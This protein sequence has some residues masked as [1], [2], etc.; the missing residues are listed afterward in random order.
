MAKLTLTIHDVITDEDVK[1]KDVSIS[2]GD[3]I[4]EGEFKRTVDF[5]QRP[6]SDFGKWEMAEQAASLTFKLSIS[7]FNVHQMMYSPDKIEAE[8]LIQAE[9]SD[10]HERKA[11]FSK[12]D[13]VGIFAKKRVS[14]TYCNT[15]KST[16]VYTV[17]SDY[18]V[19]EVVPR[20]S[21]DLMYVTLNIYSPDKLL[22]VKKYFRS[23]TAKKLYKNVLTEQ[24]PNYKLPYDS[25]KKVE[26]DASQMKHLINDTQEHIIPYLVQYNESFY[27][28]LARTTNRWGE[29]MYYHDGKLHIGFDADESKAEEISNYYSVTYRDSQSSQ[30]TQENAGSYVPEDPYDYNTLNT[31]T[32]ESSAGRTMATIMNALDMDALGDVYWMQKVRQIFACRESVISLLFNTLVDDLLMWY[33]MDQRMEDKNDKL[34]Q[35]YFTDKTKQYVSMEPE[36]YGKAGSTTTY[37]Q[38]SEAEPILTPEKYAEI[39]VGEVSAGDNT[40]EIDYDTYAPFLHIG[41]LIKVDDAPYIVTEITATQADSFVIVDNSYI[42]KRVDPRKMLFRVKA[43]AKVNLQED[44]TAIMDDFYPPVIP[45][46][47]IRQ[48]GPQIAVVVDADDPNQANRV[49]VK[50]PWQLTEEIAKLPEQESSIPLRPVYDDL[51]A[52]SLKDLDLTDATPWLLYAS[53]SGPHF[54]GVHARHYLAEKVIVNYAN[55]NIERPY[56][57]GAVSRDIPPFLTLNE[58]SAI[59]MSP[60]G[61]FI[62]LH[63]G[64]GEGATAFISKLSPGLNMVKNFFSFDDWFGDNEKS[65]YFEGG[66]EMSD[67]YGI[68]SIKCSTDSRCVMVNSPWGNVMVNAFTGIMLNAPNGD[69]RISGKNVSIEAGNNLTLTSGTNI[70]NKFASISRDKDGNFSMATFGMDVANIVGKKIISLVSSVFDLSILR[71]IVEIFW[72]PQE[73]CLTLQSNRYM[74]LSAGGARAGY[75]DAA[76]KHPEKKAKK[77]IEASTD[78]LHKD[79]AGIEQV[80]S[81]KIP[82]L[83]DHMISSYRIQ[84]NLCRTKK[85]KFDTSIR[86]LLE[87]SDANEAQNICKTY[88]QLKELFWNPATKE[89]T[90]ANL[91]FKKC[92]IADANN[93]V[94]D[95]S[96]HR[97]NVR[98]IEDVAQRR[99]EII[100]KRKTLREKVL[101]EA[102]NLL[103]AITDLRT[104][105]VTDEDFTQFHIER[106]DASKDQFTDFK[107][108]FEYDKLKDTSFYK[109]FYHKEEAV[110]DLRRDLEF[111]ANRV[112][113]ESKYHKVALMRKVAMQLAEQWGM[114]QQEIRKKINDQNVVVDMEAIEKAKV[115]DKPQTEADL[116]NNAKW[117]LYTASLTY[118]KDAA[119]APSE[120]AVAGLMA[121]D[122]AIGFATTIKDYYSWGKPN[123]GEILF[124]TGN[125]LSL[126]KDGSISKLN[127]K[128]NSA[129]LSADAISNDEKKSEFLSDIS[130]FRDAVKGVGTANNIIN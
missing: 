70:K 1:T 34:N 105:P 98:G 89:I 4:V 18:Y 103:K 104:P 122:K 108:A 58:G 30:P 44:G 28:M 120:L 26:C 84:Y 90:E 111:E 73:G 35:A 21:E 106:G 96:L 45:S 80:I 60:H 49:R 75:P 93:D 114:E 110:T 59:M 22:D 124:G 15:S 25:T 57:V 99:N 17:G 97:D 85:T 12:N 24:L 54:A 32:L 51:N 109:Y 72:K 123:A 74:K 8:I 6:V 19:H 56:V 37:N 47:H 91:D 127:T 125:T 62:K 81:F 83:V 13:L 100:E 78:L 29:F 107:K 16:D 52:D 102:N 9:S 65:K 71:S 33:M 112:V 118:T 95:I 117:E 76:Y 69:I 50:Y 11:K 68:W 43:V 40:V 61:Q 2:L 41:Q 79:I 10:T 126:K 77:A 116:E 119:K 86:K 115:P 63:E 129:K 87:Y 5:W 113:K 92:G 64:W 130:R 36:Q 66:L 7:T 88:D 46:G 48:S 94:K 53:P 23:W 82:N 27:D 101:K 42:R 121:L 3:K 31:P 38:F 14:L 39:L 67:R 128:Y 20:K 55:N